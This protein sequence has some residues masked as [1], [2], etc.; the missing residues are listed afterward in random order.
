M[1]AQF[2]VFGVPNIPMIEHGDSLGDII[3][4]AM[5]EA[6]Q[7]LRNGDVVCLAQKIVSK[8]EGQMRALAA[9]NLVQRRKPWLRPR[10]KIRVWCS[11]YWTNPPKCCAT[12]PMY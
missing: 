3:L 7:S 8:A 2:S 9:L 11:S 12:N 1:T 5:A 10:T 4:N 6:E